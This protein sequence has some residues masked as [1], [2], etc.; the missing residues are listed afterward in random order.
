MDVLKNAAIDVLGMLIP[1][2]LVVGSSTAR[3]RPDVTA[4]G[5]DRP[6]A[7]SIDGRFDRDNDVLFVEVADRKPGGEL[8]AE[9]R[10]KGGLLQFG[11]RAPR[12]RSSINATA[13]FAWSTSFIGRLD[14][15]SARYGETSPQFLDD[16]HSL[17]DASNMTYPKRR[18]SPRRISR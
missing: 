6:I 2:W 4:T 13:F 11:S 12:V 14:S 17:A 7:K 9:A 8:A 5:V 16:E 3:E 10:A 1:S 18:Y 15:K